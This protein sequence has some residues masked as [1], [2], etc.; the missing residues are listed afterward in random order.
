MGGGWAVDEEGEGGGVHPTDDAEDGVAGVS[1]G[2]GD[3]EEG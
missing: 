3:M 1:V 2:G